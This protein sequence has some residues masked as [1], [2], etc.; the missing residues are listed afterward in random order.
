VTVAAELQAGRP[1]IARL[2]EPPHRRRQEALSGRR[3]AD[4]IGSVQD[5]AR[6]HELDPFLLAKGSPRPGGA[7]ALGE[8]ELSFRGRV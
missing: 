4:W 2:P 8:Q 1:E 6:V 3:L 5:V 7:R